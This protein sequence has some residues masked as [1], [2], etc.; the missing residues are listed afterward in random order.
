M[1]AGRQ[2]VARL[3]TLIGLHYKYGM[4]LVGGDKGN[5][6]ECV[7]LAASLFVWIELGWLWRDGRSWGWSQLDGYQRPFV[8]F[9]SLIVFTIGRRRMH[10]DHAPDYREGG[11]TCNLMHHLRVIRCS[12]RFVISVAKAEMC[13]KRCISNI[14]IDTFPKT[15]CFA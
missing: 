1:A 4:P 3:N 6:D 9:E 7:Y 13:V 10:S 2:Q 8:F 11:K 12:K 14:N 5:P 15:V